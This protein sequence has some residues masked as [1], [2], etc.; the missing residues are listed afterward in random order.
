VQAIETSGGAVQRVRAN[1]LDIT[2]DY[3]IAAMPVEVMTTLLTDDLKAAAQSLANLS[4]LHTRWMNGIQ[5][6]LR[7]DVPLAYGHAIYLNSPWALTSISQRQFWTGVD[8]G[9]FGD[10][11]V[12]GILSVDISEWE[13]P[14][15]LY[16]KSAMQCS[17]QEVKDEVWAQLKQHLN[18]SG[19]VLID[20]ADL[21]TWFLDPDIQFPNPTLVTNLEPLLINTAGSLKY[22][23]EAQVELSNL[24][25]ASD[26]VRTYT[27]LATMEGANEAARRA[28]NCLLLATGS[29]A[30]AAQL[31]PL[32][33]PEFLKPLQE[34]DRIRF[35]LGQAHHLM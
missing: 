24:F 13:A 11:S 20:D 22:R 9:T 3:Y 10:G 27:D 21:V 25:L 35:R 19:E 29:K 15:V 26:Y 7:R 31:W 8:F 12:Q 5:F 28:V 33:E 30:P 4:Q 34:I 32:S 6:Y 17:A 2:A 1:A 23:P 14:G 16:S 18:V